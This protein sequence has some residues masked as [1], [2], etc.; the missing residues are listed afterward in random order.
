MEAIINTL[1]ATLNQTN[2]HFTDKQVTWLLNHVGAL[3][4]A[5]RDDLV[6]QLLG[7]GLESQAFTDSQ[8]QQIIQPI[9]KEHWLFK[10]IEEPTNDRVFLRSFT[11]L[12]TTEILLSH[13]SLAY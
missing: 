9:L 11:A 6:Y 7:R 1:Q 3:D 5:I 13:S 2:L 10:S 8:K 4:P 12:L